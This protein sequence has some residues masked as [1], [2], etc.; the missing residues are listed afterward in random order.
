MKKMLI[1]FFL[2]LLLFCRSSANNPEIIE[3]DNIQVIINGKKANLPSPILLANDS[4]L[5]PLRNLLQFLPSSTVEIFWYPKE[6]QVT[7]LAE[8]SKLTFQINSDTALL[9]NTP[10]TLSAIPILYKNQTF[11]PLRIV[12]EFLDCRI[13]WD[14]PSKSVFIKTFS[15][16]YEA[17]SIFQQSNSSLKKINSVKM[18]IINEFTY[19]EGDFSFGHSVYVDKNTNAIYTKNMLDSE[20]KLS[21][22]NYLSDISDYQEQLLPF[23]FSIDKMKSSEN[24]YVLTGFYPSKKGTLIESSLF[25]DTLTFQL[26]KMISKTVQ[27]T[28]NVLYQYEVKL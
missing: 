11:I 18:D 3:S 24:T 25:I 20:W 5:F 27:Q 12:S 1:L 7:L 10:F 6:Q 28:Q 17:E 19:P 15:D 26:S 22:E 8:N 23:C 9:N 14:N 16:F 4:L 21:A 2:F 13:A